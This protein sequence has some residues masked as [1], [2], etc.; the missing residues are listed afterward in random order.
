MSGNKKIR[1]IKDTY[2]GVLGA[3]VMYAQKDEHMQTQVFIGTLDECKVLAGAY[4][5]IGYDIEW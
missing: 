4:A 5:A 1:I 2:G 3:Y